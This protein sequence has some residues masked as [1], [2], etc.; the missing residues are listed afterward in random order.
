MCSRSLTL[1]PD[2][3]TITIPYCIQWCSP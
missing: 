1:G 2:A 3:L